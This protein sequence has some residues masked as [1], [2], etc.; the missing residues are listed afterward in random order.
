MKP[1]ASTTSRAHTSEPGVNA[2]NE[3]AIRMVEN[4]AYG[5][6]IA[7]TTSGDNT[8]MTKNKLLLKFANA[9]RKQ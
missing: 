3:N 7:S 6:A 2:S 5:T 1:I 4:E 9:R 8:R